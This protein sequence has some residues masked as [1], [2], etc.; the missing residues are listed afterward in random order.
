MDGF[1]RSAEKFLAFNPGTHEQGIIDSIEK[2]N[3]IPVATVKVGSKAIKVLGRPTYYPGMSV[4]F[5]DVGKTGGDIP[6]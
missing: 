5:V 4:A 2:V 6:L 1:R 3:N